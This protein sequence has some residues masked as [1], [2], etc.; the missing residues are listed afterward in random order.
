MDFPPYA[1]ILLY[2]SIVCFSLF[3]WMSVQ[4]DLPYS[5]NFWLIF[6]RTVHLN[7]PTDRRVGCLQFF[8]VECNEQCFPEHPSAVL[9]CTCAQ[10]LEVELQ[11]GQTRLKRLSSSS[12]MCLNIF[13][14]VAKPPSKKASCSLQSV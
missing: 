4:V 8:D 13:I 5:F 1:I 7:A 14:A 3:S 10:Y 12:R 2:C 9:S 6:P 11:T